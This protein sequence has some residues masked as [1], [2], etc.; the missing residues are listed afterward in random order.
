MAVRRTAQRP[1]VSAMRRAT[2][3]STSP[4][5]PARLSGAERERCQLGGGV[6][7]AGGDRHLGCPHVAGHA[8]RPRRD[9]SARSRRPGPG[10]SRRASGRP[11]RRHRPPRTPPRMLCWSDPD[12]AHRRDGH[13]GQR[14]ARRGD[15][16]QLAGRESSSQAHPA[17]A[18]QG[19]DRHRQRLVL[20][21]RDHRDAEGAEADA[22]A[23][24][25]T[26]QSCRASRPTRRSAVV[27]GHRHRTR[28]R[29]PRRS[30]ATAARGA[31]SAAA[32]RGG[33][34]A[35]RRGCPPTGS[36][37]AASTRSGR[38]APA[39]PGSA[40]VEGVDQT[41][42]LA[43]AQAG[44]EPPHVAAHVEQADPAARRCRPAPA[45][46]RQLDAR[47][48]VGPD[49]GS[50]ST[51]STTSAD[52]SGCRADPGLAPT[53]RDPPVDRPRLDRPL[54]GTNVGEVEA[55]PAG[56]RRVVPQPDA[57]RGGESRAC[58]WR[59]V[60]WC[61]RANRDALHERGHEQPEAVAGLDGQARRRGQAPTSQPHRDRHH[62]RRVRYP[63]DD[64]ARAVDRLEV[65]RQLEVELHPGAPVRERIS[66]T[67]TPSRH[68]RRRAPGR[69]RR[70]P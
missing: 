56:L 61:Q 5:E 69:R 29:P 18:A 7:E 9:P 11:G 65:G 41:V 52:R 16:A 30:P 13:D 34:S 15:K 63:G 22:E 50:R 54:R 14:G 43:M 32:R 17:D 62:E 6:E 24:R 53:G 26:A 51:N 2:S 49:P 33:T 44:L 20:P 46:H 67:G 38:R 39:R 10:R 60:G 57:Q 59:S 42:E 68:P 58:I 37:G 3:S 25:S 8:R 21:P 19:G 64:P 70:R 55:R 1:T 40:P 27:S 12:H 66:I 36:A 45:A 47:V 35:P 31:G 28:R 23:A 4:V 48:R